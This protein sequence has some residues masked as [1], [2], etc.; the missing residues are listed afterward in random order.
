MSFNVQWS[1]QKLVQINII[2]FSGKRQ[3]PLSRAGTFIGIDT[4]C[5]VIATK[6]FFID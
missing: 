2:L 1:K 5:W 3:G 6:H 4:V